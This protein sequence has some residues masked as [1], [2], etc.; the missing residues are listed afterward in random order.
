MSAISLA[1][2]V[3]GA[4]YVGEGGEDTAYARSAGNS[5][6]EP[7]SIWVT[8]GEE[9]VGIQTE[10]IGEVGNEVGD[11]LDVVDVVFGVWGALPR[12]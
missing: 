5:I 7:A 11:E 10:I 2:T 6:C 9:A 4:W 8:G 1:A 12:G 3:D